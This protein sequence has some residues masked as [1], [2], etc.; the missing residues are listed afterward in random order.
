M[1]DFRFALL[2]MDVLCFVSFCFVF[3]NCFFV[4]LVDSKW[5]FRVFISVICPFSSWFCYRRQHMFPLSSIWIR[6]IDVEHAHT[7]TLNHIQI[8]NDELSRS[9]CA[10]IISVFLYLGSVIIVI[11]FIA[12]SMAVS[13]LLFRYVEIYSRALWR[14]KLSFIFVDRSV[15]ADR[16]IKSTIAITIAITI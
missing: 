6:W 8:S 1:H 12:L 14:S 16:G 4:C 3:S 5:I 7:L 9:L 15:S 10:S 13:P 2:A 11:C